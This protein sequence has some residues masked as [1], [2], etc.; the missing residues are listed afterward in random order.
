[1]Y[2]INP[3]EQLEGNLVMPGDKS[4]SHRL[5]I[6]ASL[7][8]GDSWGENF[9]ISDDSLRTIEAFRQLGIDI[10]E[11]KNIRIK[12]K[13]LRGL[14]AP[15]EPL[16]MGGSGTSAR[17]ILGV[18]AGQKFKATL[19]GDNSLSK[20][21]MKRV[22]APLREMG[23]KIEG[24]QEA[25]FLPLS[26]EG[27]DL[28]P[29]EY[30]MPVAS[31]QVKSAILLAGL[32]AEGKTKVIEPFISRDHTERLLKLFGAKLEK[33]GLVNII[34]GWPELKGIKFFIPGDISSASNF[35]ALATLVKKA[36]LL[37]S[38][39]GLNPTRTGI[40]DVLKRMG[41]K[42]EVKVREE[43][44]TAEPYGD[45]EIRNASLRGVKVTKEEIPRL[46]DE[47]PL[48]MVLACFAE[49]VTVI[50]GTEELRVKETDRINSMV[51]NLR[52]MGAKIEVVEDT[53]V[54]EGGYPLKPAQVSSFGDHRT[55]MSMVVM[56]S[57][58]K[59]D[60]V[61]DDTDCIKKSFPDFFDFLFQ[62]VKR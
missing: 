19:T 26:I 18:L 53:I 28:K 46:I 12:G 5:V 17:L 25:D 4:I 29:I 45:I 41:A 49:G 8:E 21:P 13:G 42:I 3:I 56:G 48:L 34:S 60:T 55:A 27:N 2:K 40:L 44:S 38:S 37:I 32:Y 58:L 15:R 50:E 59:G 57:V 61:L 23:A 30:R 10:E 14:K 62:V 52:K 24:P 7:A 54:V 22:T 9:L 16:Y 36:H 6:L 39:V 43:S 11:G 33:D 51:T 1:M 20:R 31:A 47:L 35:I